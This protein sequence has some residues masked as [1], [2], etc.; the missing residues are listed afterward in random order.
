MRDKTLPI[1]PTGNYIPPQ[2]PYQPP[3]MKGNRRMLDDSDSQPQK[4]FRPPV[5]FPYGNMPGMNGIQAQPYGTAPQFPPN[6]ITNDL[7]QTMLNQPMFNFAGNEVFEFGDVTTTDVR[8]SSNMSGGKVTVQSP[9][10]NVQHPFPQVNIADNL[11]EEIDEQQK[12][13]SVSQGNMPNFTM[14][15]LGSNTSWETGVN[16]FEGESFKEMRRRSD[17]DSGIDSESGSPWS[18]QAPSPS[19]SVYTSPPSV[20]SGVGHSP[21]HESQFQHG[22]SPPKYHGVTSPASSYRATPS[23]ANTS[24]YGSPGQPQLEDTDLINETLLEDAM[25]VINADMISEEH[26][27]NRQ[28][29]T[30]STTQ[31]QVPVMMPNLNINQQAMT[32][33]QLPQ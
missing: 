9:V 18:E 19:S 15:Q 31:Q 20:E 16:N 3:Q 25:A 10:T 23:P 2:I 7:N 28:L 13:A 8:S 26:K 11:L 5:S 27:K 6:F 29:S 14:G 4:Y 1:G 32:Q 22:M 12:M 33:P 30:S 21:K 17:P 24:G